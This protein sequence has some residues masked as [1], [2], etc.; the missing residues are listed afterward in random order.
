MFDWGIN[1]LFMSEFVQAEL[2]VASGFDLRVLEERR[3]LN[4]GCGDFVFYE[5]GCLWV[6]EEWAG[7][8]CWSLVLLVKEWVLLLFWT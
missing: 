5:V 7:V 3:P 2:C 8:G 6:H 4:E 1:L